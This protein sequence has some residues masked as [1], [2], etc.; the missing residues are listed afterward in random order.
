MYKAIRSPKASHALPTMYDLPSEEI[1][2]PGLPDQYHLWQAELLSQTFCPP[3]YNSDQI[4]VAGDLN[5]YYD[6]NHTNWYKRPDWFGVVGIDRFYKKVDSRLSYVIWDEKVT[7]LIIA[8]FL[9]PGT[10]KDDLG[11]KKAKPGK[12]PTK[13]QVYE[14]I[15]KIPYYVVFNRYENKIYFFEL[16]NGKY[17]EIALTNSKFWLP[18]IELG[19]GLWLGSYQG[20][21][22]LWLRWYDK[23]E[24]WIPT[25]VERE[26]QR[27]DILA[28]HLRSL[29]INPDDITS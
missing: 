26:K 12:P 5:L 27:A 4:L 20:L 23:Q 11:L 1:G 25:P 2:D 10:D 16:V 29:G 8:E 3:N 19:L 18:E 9:S 24:N 15:L 14:Q 22:R 28:A 13:W 17:R 6:V 7:P 21:N